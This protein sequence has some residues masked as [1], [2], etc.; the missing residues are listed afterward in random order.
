[1]ALVLRSLRSAVNAGVKIGQQ[2]W[3]QPLVL[4]VQK[5]IANYSFTSHQ[6]PTLAVNK[7]TFVLCW[8]KHPTF[9]CR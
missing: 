9:Q 7:V 2:S 4:G 1:M 8:L 3:H 5:Q 6:I